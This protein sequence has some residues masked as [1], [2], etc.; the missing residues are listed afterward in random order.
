MT[1]NVLILANSR[2]LRGRCVAGKDEDGNWIRLVKP[3]GI[4]IPTDEANDLNILYIYIVKGLQYEEGVCEYHTENH[5]YA[6]YKLVDSLSAES[7]IIKYLDNP[8]NI[9]GSTRRKL[10]PNEF[11]NFDKSLLLVKVNNLLIQ[12]VRTQYGVRNRCNFV[13][14]NMDYLDFSLTDPKYEENFKLH[15]IGYEEN[16]E[17]AYLTISLGEPYDD[18]C[19]YKLVAGVITVED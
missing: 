12:K 3:N 1:K 15:D 4:S 2:K 17:R 9:Y 7:Q 16:Y 8:L 10:Y 19:A 14:N 6:S 5:T 13:Y 11:C 18:G